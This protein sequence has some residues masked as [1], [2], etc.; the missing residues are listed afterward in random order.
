MFEYELVFLKGNWEKVRSI[1]LPEDDKYIAE[2]Y[3]TL[4]GVNYK[5]QQL[6]DYE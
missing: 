2:I 6:T 5:W 3:K 1:Y 4:D